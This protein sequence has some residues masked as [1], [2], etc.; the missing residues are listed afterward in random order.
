[1][2]IFITGGSGFLGGH[3]TEALLNGGHNCIIYD[4]KK[5]NYNIKNAKFCEGDLLDE[6]K[7]ERLLKNIDIIYHFAGEADIDNSNKNPLAAVQNNILATTKL[8]NLSVKKKIKRFVFAS[9][10]YVYSEQGGFYRTT[11]QACELLIENYHNI[12]KLNFTILRFGSLYGPRANNFNWLNKEITN[13]KKNKNI[14]RETSGNELR[15]YI[16][17]LDAAKL[18]LMALSSKYKNKYLMLTG[19]QS[20]TVKELLKLLKE[21]SG[22]K[23]KISYNNKKNTRD[24]YMITPFSFKPRMASKI[25]KEEEIDLGQGLYDLIF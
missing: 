22:S 21:I 4:I 9:S 8:L 10:V 24:H 15:S 2:N 17:V 23:S 12:Y 13:I 18:S 5:P 20:V 6:K 1:M 11:K 16:H 19:S 3:L 14:V 7:I 25:K